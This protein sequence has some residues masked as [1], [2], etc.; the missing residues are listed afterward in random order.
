MRIF[1]GLKEFEEIRQLPPEKIEEESLAA[2]RSEL[3]GMGIS[4]PGGNEAVVLRCIHA[5]ADFDYARNLFFSEDAVRCLS[6]IFRDERPALVTDTKMAFS[7]ISDLACKRFGIEKFCF[8]SDSDV[9]ACSKSTGLTRSACAVDK[10]ALTFGSRP[11]VYAVGN[12]PTALV[13]IRQLSDSG[14]FRPSFVVA[15]PVGFVNVE[16]AKSLIER[17]GLDCI[18]ARKRKGGSPIAAAIVNAV[19]YS[20]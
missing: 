13:R 15:A 8:I 4:V 7:G 16:A 19:L 18:V 20:L 17:S 2:I 5:S 11:V 12:A 10:A 14:I 3:A 1:G 6:R 9:A